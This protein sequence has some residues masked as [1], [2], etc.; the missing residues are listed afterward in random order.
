MSI[1]AVRG[2]GAADE[3]PDEAAVI[4]ELDSLRPT[5][6]EAATVDVELQFEQG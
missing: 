1:V 2:N 5:A 3:S 4:L 6:A